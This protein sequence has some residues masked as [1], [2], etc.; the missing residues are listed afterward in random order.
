[1]CISD[2]TRVNEWEERDRQTDRETE[3]ERQTETEN[4]KT[5]EASLLHLP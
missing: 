2:T 5:T 3:T 1:M 4:M